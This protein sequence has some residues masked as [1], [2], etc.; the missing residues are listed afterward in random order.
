[1]YQQI[2]Y[3]S[4]IMSFESG[5]SCVGA[6]GET[7]LSPIGAVQQAGQRWSESLFT[8]GGTGVGTHLA[9][10]GVLLDYFGGY[11]PPRHLYTDSIYRVW[12]ALP[13]SSGDFWT[14]AVLDLMYPGYEGASYF[15]DESGF[16]T[17]TPFMDS[18]DVLLNDAPAWLLKRYSTLIVATKLESMRAETTAKLEAFVESGGTVLVSADTLTDMTLLGV[19]VTE[20]VHLLPYLF[21]LWP[22]EDS[23]TPHTSLA[24]RALGC[25]V[26]CA[27][28]RLS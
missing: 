17:P 11:T 24:H 8:N 25:V 3:G 22:F 26:H 13:F 27:V 23:H 28:R 20:V 5:L 19:S 15:H 2:L 7:L 10:T 12:G 21:S 6:A 14:H 18:A 9:T 4:S 16:L 1:M